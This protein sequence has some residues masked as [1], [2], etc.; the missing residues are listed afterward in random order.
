VRLLFR[1]GDVTARDFAQVA[2]SQDLQGKKG[3]AFM[4]M[5]TTGAFGRRLGLLIL[6]ASALALALVLL[7]VAAASGEA[8]TR[9]DRTS[10]T[11]ATAATSSGV[12]R[13]VVFAVHGGAGTITR[14]NTPP[15]LEAQYRDALRQALQRGYDVIRRGGESTEAVEAAIVFLEDSPLFNAGKGA[16]FTTDAGHEL[17]ASIMDGET[18]D[19][20]A[21]TGVTHIKNPIQ[22]AQKVKDSSRHVMFAGYGAELFA[23]NRGFSLVTQDYFFVQ[24]R[25]DSLLAAKRGE[26]TFNFGLTGTV[27]AVALD[28]EGDLAAGTSTGGLTNKPVGRIGD[29][30]IIGAGTYANNRTVAV[31]ATGTGEF[32]IRQVVA[33][34]ISALMDYAR[35]RVD[36]AAETAIGKVASLGGDGGVIALDKDAQFAMPFN[37]A[38][39]FRG[40]VT[41]DG[42]IVVKMFGDE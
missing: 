27:G 4:G 1:D 24:R 5:L 17:D 19:T 32:F 18:L 21:V 25:W 36:K 23:V 35:M 39:M 15:E 13:D 38:G 10:A 41:R 30:P 6:P 37:T 22:L 9:S 16:V 3:G 42:Q 26:S 12:V 31:S 33:H 28:A 7:A 8:R 29:S 40:Y 34:D 2:L 14:A 20:G 11:D